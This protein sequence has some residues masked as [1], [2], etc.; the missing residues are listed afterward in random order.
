MYR[1]VLF[2][3]VFSV[4]ALLGPTYLGPA[5][6]K[7]RGNPPSPVILRVETVMCRYGAAFFVVGLLSGLWLIWLSPFVPDFGEARW[8]HTALGLFFIAA[9]IVTGFILPRVNKA[10]V[11]AEG[12]DAAE[13]SR[14][15]A[16][17]DAVAGPVVGLLTAV[18]LYLMLTKPWS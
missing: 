9:G 8:L 16:P 14:L 17:V 13:A 7:L 15:M 6:A 3:H 10:A 5:L 1:I 2:V 18:I 4:V 11:A 12:G